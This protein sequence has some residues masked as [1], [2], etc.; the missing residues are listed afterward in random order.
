M[1]TP[2]SPAP[3]L[4][5]PTLADC[6]EMLARYQRL[7]DRD[8][9]ALVAL[10]GCCRDETVFCLGNGPS[11]A[12]QDPR[13]LTGSNV[14]A[15]N[16]GHRFLR[17]VAP[18]RHWN[19]VTDT[20]R[21]SEVAPELEVSRQPTFHAPYRLTAEWLELAERHPMFH[22]LPTTQYVRWTPAGWELAARDT[23]LCAFRLPDELEHCGFSVIF[24]A[25]ELA[26][27]FG[28]RT[29]VLLGVD[30]DYGG[31]QSHFAPGVV[32]LNA[33]YNYDTHAR[34][35]FVHF[36][37]VLE[38][39]GIRLLNATDGGRV[40]TLERIS[41]ADA[42]TLSELRAAKAN[43]LKNTHELTM[44]R[45]QALVAQVPAGRPVV[46]WG[47]NSLSVA[48][49]DLLAE[50]GVKPYAVV[51]R[52]A[53]EAETPAAFASRLATEPPSL[54]PFYVV[55]SR[56]ARDAIIADLTQA[57]VNGV[58]NVAVLPDFPPLGAA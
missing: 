35:A 31:P 3:R 6:V 11:L 49:G 18:R 56:T 34:S 2:I 16:H 24:A 46:L 58:E 21:L 20:V 7:V 5:D 43:I 1:N 13:L 15:T 14:I 30:M 4:D 42:V 32:H 41:L 38:T 33:H 23:P 47:A 25:I 39:R 40:D 17:G 51:D 10:G 48:V 8:R 29:I 55:C 9:P 12:R 26:V 22:V 44:W 27:H 53:G 45:A 37:R 28:A 36:R 54:P 50:R 52:C 57:G 19:L